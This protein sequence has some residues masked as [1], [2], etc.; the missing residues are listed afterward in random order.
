MSIEHYFGGCAAWVGS[1]PVHL[2]VT[3]EL[4]S[5]V[6]WRAPHVMHGQFDRVW[7][8]ERELFSYG[9]GWPLLL[10]ECLRLLGP[11]GYLITR[12]RDSE[13][14][15]LFE[16]KSIVARR[17]NISAELVFQEKLSGGDTVTV[18][19]VQR[20]NLSAYSEDGWT[21]GI[22][23]NGAKSVNVHSLAEKLTKL[24]GERPLQIVIAGPE[25]LVM[26]PHVTGSKEEW[27][28]RSGDN[29]PR[30]GEKKNWIVRQARHSNIAIF[31]DRYQIDDNFFSGFEKFGLDFDFVSI[32]QRY[33]SGA[34]YPSYIGFQEGKM[35]WQRPQF[36]LSY[37]MLH[38]GHFINGGLIVLKRS[39]AEVLN[40]N[41]LLLHNEAEDVEL[42]LMLRSIGIFPRMNS[43]S[44]AI[45]IGVPDNYTGT[46]R[47]VTSTPTLLAANRLN[48]IIH[49][50]AFA[51]W[52]RLPYAAKK[53]IKKSRIYVTLKRYLRY[54]G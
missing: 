43:Y 3:I 31:H 4:V 17:P 10:D 1:K 7:L 28:D 32:S 29:L 37:T 23:S 19:D 6:N 12:T 50:V 20:G 41:A 42:S 46:F 33:E 45:A 54:N 53:L 40:F 2:A 25:K 34:Y 11:R 8:Y 9:S 47:D 35:R 30:I 5:A 21:I 22:L 49:R 15:T 14:G 26:P 16:L 51:G 18:I 13:H 52:H 38:D 48:V 36:D 27:N 44:S 39:V 24:A